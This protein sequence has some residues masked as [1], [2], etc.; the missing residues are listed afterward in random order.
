LESDGLVGRFLSLLPF[1]LTGAQKRVLSDI[2]QDLERPE[3]MARLVQGDVGSGKTVVAIAALLRAVEAGCQG[4][5]M[6]PTEVL[7]AQHY[8]NLCHW[9]PPLHV[10]VELLTGSTPRRSRR[11]IL[12]DL[13]G[14]TLR[15]LVGTH[16]LLEDPVAFDR[17]GL[18]V[19]DEQ[20]R[21]GVRQRN[22]LLD[23]GLQ[24]H[25]L[26]MTATPIP[27]TLALSLHGDLD[28]S[29]IDELPPGRTPIRTKVVK[30]SEREE[31][32]ELIR[33]QVLQGQR[34]YVVLPLVE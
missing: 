16:A 9:L 3:P 25:L 13:S 15:I 5:L 11:Q 28:V 14:G 23:K 1:E 34:I 24:P 18:V 8:R 20:H 7:A 17:L 31:A 30:S 33:E 12:S 26:T 29:Q 10:S 6:A 27:R 2:E 32:Y 22:R 19:V 21:F 4:A